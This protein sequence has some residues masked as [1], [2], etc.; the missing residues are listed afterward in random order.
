MSYLTYYKDE[1]DTKGIITKQITNV[2]IKDG[3]FLLYRFD[4]LLVETKQ[5]I[6]FDCKSKI[7]F[8]EDGSIVVELY[9]ED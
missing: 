1:N 2:K 4:T 9:Q 3:V 6:Y 5:P 7:L 8:K